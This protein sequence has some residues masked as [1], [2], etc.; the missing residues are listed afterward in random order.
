TWLVLAGESETILH[1]ETLQA[2][3]RLMVFHHP[4]E[5]LSHFL[6]SREKGRA[7]AAF[8]RM[9]AYQMAEI[10]QDTFARIAR[11]HSVTAIAGS[12]ILPAPQI[13]SGQLV[14]HQGPLYNASVVY[15]SDGIARQP[16]IRKAFPTARELTFITPASASDIPSFD[17]PAGRLGVLV[18]A[19]S[20][21]PPAY[22]ALKKQQIDLLAVPSYDASGMQSWN[23]PWRGYDGW[24]TPADVDR[25]DIEKITEGQAWNK[26]ALAGRMRA[27]GAM[28]GM[29]VFLRGKLWNQDL[30]GWPATL[31][32]GDDVFVEEQT[33]KAALLS[34]WL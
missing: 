27:S 34:L 8:F 3:E 7:E 5:F 13:S 32:R 10:Y 4:L 16:L 2:A 29:N 26:Y 22:A 1:A 20:W 15:G 28:Y 11:E 14:T 31:V 12:I 17:T 6:T 21:Y 18:C 23:Q 19:D 25:T 24:Q 9:K 33:Q 30:G